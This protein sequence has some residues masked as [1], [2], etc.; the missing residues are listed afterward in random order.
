LRQIS[1]T[2]RPSISNVKTLEMHQSQH[3]TALDA[4]AIAALV[5]QAI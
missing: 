2:V 4:H 3:M 1:D 5:I